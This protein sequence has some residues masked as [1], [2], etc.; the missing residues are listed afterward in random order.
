MKRLTPLALVVLA[1]AVVP[2]ALADDT[3]PAAPVDSTVSAQQQP[4][5]DRA[6]RLEQL[7]DRIKTAVERFQKHCG[8]G[9]N[10]APERCSDV[11]KKAAE[12]LAKLDA[13]VQARIA[14]I[15]ETC[16]ATSTD[17]KC[18]HADERIAQLRK[19]DER[20]TAFAAKVQAWL[21][22]TSTGT[23][24]SDAAVDQAASKLGTLA[25]SK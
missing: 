4:A 7:R 6:Q 11:A 9:A 18:K 5:N 10:G 17:E 3:T 24:S 1:L 20:V 25:G 19:V 14:K 13:N 8:T 22:G 16:T 12:R 23:P 21:N 2:V 15:Q